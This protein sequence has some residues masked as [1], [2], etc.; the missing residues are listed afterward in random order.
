M[1]DLSRLRVSLTKHNAHKIARLLKDYK[2][3]QILARLDEV[4]AEEAQAHKNL[5]VLPGDKVPEVWTKVRSLGDGAI[6]A[7]VLVG[8]IFSH[9]E[10][11]EAMSNASERSGL[12]GRIERGVQLDGKAYTNFARVIDQLGFATKLDYPGVSFNLRAMFEVPGLGPLVGELLGYKLDAARW[13]RVGTVADEAV[14][15]DFHEVFGISA[16]EL[17]KWLTTDVQPAGAGNSLLPKDEE[18]FQAGDE[19]EKSKKF[20]FVPGHAERAVEPITKDASAKTKVNQLHNDIQNRLYK[21]L[22][23][24]LGKHYVGTELNT[25][26]GTSI[27]V[28]T[29]KNGKITFYEI[30]TSTSVRTSIRQAIP[31]LL[32]YAYWPA[33]RRADD[34][35]IVSH[36]P[37]T[38]TAER[39]LEFLRVQFKIP[40]AYRQFDLINDLL[41]NS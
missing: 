38:R 41:V 37:V 24:Q 35:V 32:E 39:Y 15:Q 23:D 18:F 26:S 8:I 31:Q 2:A 16:N 11:I 9:H 34:L 36:L 21:Y 6:D 3:D 5:S 40:L 33:E 19:G 12:A 13:N 14:A 22:C 30:K 1:T 28:V 29:K 20:E 17:K 4:H 27:D 25:G 7:L 10:L